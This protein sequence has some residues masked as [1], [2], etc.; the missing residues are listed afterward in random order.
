LTPGSLLA[1]RA[2]LEDAQEYSAI[3]P[4]LPDYNR[5]RNLLF[6]RKVGPPAKPL[7]AHPSALSHRVSARGKRASIARLTL[8]PRSFPIRRLRRFPRR[9][10][11]VGSRCLVAERIAARVDLAAALSCRGRRLQPP[12]R[13]DRSRVLR[14]PAGAALLAELTPASAR[15]ITSAATVSPDTASSGDQSGSP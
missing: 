13:R 5:G 12:R 15:K 6:R 3:A 10:H 1:G 11:S 14:P 4:L 7:N 8:G 9:P 2:W